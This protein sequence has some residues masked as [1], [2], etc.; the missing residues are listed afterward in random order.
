MKYVPSRALFMPAAYQPYRDRASN[1]GGSPGSHGAN[2]CSAA[3]R[4]DLRRQRQIPLQMQKLTRSTAVPMGTLSL[5]GWTRVIAP[6]LRQQ[7]RRTYAQLSPQPI[8]GSISSVAIA[9]ML[10]DDTPGVT[11]LDPVLFLRNSRLHISGYLPRAGEGWL[12]SSC[13]L[14][15]RISFLTINADENPRFHIFKIAH[16]G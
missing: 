8:G 7:Q 11:L 2:R 15:S 1:S 10:L 6:T 13:H 9:T 12:S 14:A 3:T 5:T 4:Y 16:T